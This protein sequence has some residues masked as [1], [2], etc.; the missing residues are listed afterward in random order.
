V[1]DETGEAQLRGSVAS[2]FAV[3]EFSPPTTTVIESSPLVGR[4]GE[5]RPAHA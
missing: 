2:A 5:K 4:F 1:N 3:G